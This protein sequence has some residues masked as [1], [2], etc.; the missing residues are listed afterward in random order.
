MED[1]KDYNGLSGTV[2]KKRKQDGYLWVDVELK[3]NKKMGWWIKPENLKP[4]K[5][6]KV[7]PLF[8][9][10]FILFWLY[11]ISKTFRQKLLKVSLL[12]RIQ[13]HF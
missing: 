8:C 11:L 4:K 13:D 6:I 9:H 3:E 7:S 12:Q 5:S 1:E 2:I 10:D